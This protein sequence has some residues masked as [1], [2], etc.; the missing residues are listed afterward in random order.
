MDAWPDRPGEGSAMRVHL[1]LLHGAG[2]LLLVEGLCGNPVPAG[3]CDR[4]GVDDATDL[5]NGTH[6][7]CNRNGVPDLCEFRAIIDLTA[8]PVLSVAENPVSALLADLDHD[9]LP[10]LIIENLG[11]WDPPSA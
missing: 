2:L 5:Q 10:D 3:D 1:P 6:A 9:S 8:L 11:P 7:D 4:N